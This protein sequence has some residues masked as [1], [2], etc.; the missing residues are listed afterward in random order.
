MQQISPIE[1]RVKDLVD[2]FLAD[3]ITRDEFERELSKEKAKLGRKQRTLPK[4]R[5]RTGC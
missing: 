3:E 5:G 4:D 1:I 2:A